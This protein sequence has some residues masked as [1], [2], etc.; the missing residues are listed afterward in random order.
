MAEK[1]EGD[2]LVEKERW[3]SDP[4]VKGR[5]ASAA[6]YT[7]EEPV[8]GI[9]KGAVG[10]LT[11]PYEGLRHLLDP[12]GGISLHIPGTDIG[13]RASL[14]NLGV[15]LPTAKDMPLYKPFLDQPEPAND[16]GR[17][18]RAGGEGVGGS[19][20]PTGT[21]LANAQKLKNLT[22]IIEGTGEHLPASNALKGLVQ[23]VGGFFAR[24]PGTA[25]MAD[26]AG[27]S[28]AGVGM[29]AARDAELGP[30]F[31]IAAGAAAPLV[32][33]GGPVAAVRT[34]RGLLR[35][36]DD[37]FTPTVARW[38]ANGDAIFKRLG[39]PASA[40]GALPAAESA[41]GEAA[42]YMTL[43][44]TLRRANV[45]IEQLDTLLTR[46][47]ESRR[48]YS[49]S[50]A[51]DAVALV[52]L[53]PAL[54]KIAG[55]LMRENPEVWKRG[56][57]FMY[58]RQTGVTPPRGE[59]PTDTG[60]PARE[61]YAPPI[62]GLQAL[63]EFGT[64][65]GTP[66]KSIVP[67]GQRERVGDAFKRALRIE[68]AELHGHAPTASMTDTQLE[69]YAGTA[70]KPAYDATRA[71]A[72]G[73]DL[74][75]T[76][77]PIL[78]RW[79]RAAEA[80][81]GPVGAALRRQI[82]E[83]RRAIEPRDIVISGRPV[84]PFERF[85]KVKQLMD[86]IIRGLYNAGA[87]REKQSAI[88]GNALT[89]FK[90]ELLKGATQDGV[91]I[92]PGVDDIAENGLGGLYSKARGIYSGV[93]NARRALETGN[94]IWKGEAGLDEFNALE[95]DIASQ[96]LVRLGIHGGYE[97]D[98]KS[99]PGGRDVTNLFDKPRLD[100][101]LREII[102]RSGGEV[103]HD[104]PE[105]FGRY[106]AHEQMMGGTAK[107]TYQGSPTSERIADDRAAKE[108]FDLTDTL[109]RGGWQQVISD[110]AAD[111]LNKMFGY[112]ADTAA[113]MGR[114]LFTAD[115]KQRGMAIEKI[116]QHM[117]DDR[118]TYF[119][120]LMADRAQRMVQ[121][122]AAVAP[123]AA[124]N[125]APPEDAIAFLRQNGNSADIRRQFEE[126]YGVSADRYLGGR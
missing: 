57:D 53:D 107:R 118:F 45:P 98:T 105:R 34:A 71:A 81:A 11:L 39:I 12:E 16:V 14:G 20:I 111:T 76:V 66:Q 55:T 100:E 124:S 13:G 78:Q 104:T 19:V 82:K 15:K 114:V 116:R 64:T 83:V 70:S 49:N 80:E 90:N 17:Y 102:P 108:L 85:D 41:G 97:A 110:F 9:N 121:A 21:I 18:L 67:M 46:I 24:K 4:I 92:L 94:K 28:A 69:A 117:G 95:G 113:T 23:Q 44:N 25:V 56:V 42:A 8:R 126:K 1:W 30:G 33:V 35:V 74:R 106:I 65:F 40:D 62:T 26:V 112:R 58:A 84:S 7:V 32:A 38:K 3:E 122:G 36:P 10:L 91:K 96:K 51:P 52:D 119:Q 48:F 5:D 88:T 63:E 103:F 54:Q 37:A 101:V 27:A 115:P 50:Y 109:R 60:I 77:E 73:V 29:Q 123:G 125:R 79:E 75:P 99:L 6:P 93:A 87:S 47:A 43:A 2:P 31:E 120:K 89:Q 86:E 72:K 61:K 68:D 22:P 59:L